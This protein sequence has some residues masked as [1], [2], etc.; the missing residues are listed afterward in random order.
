M[1]EHRQMKRGARIAIATVA[2]VSP[3][4]LIALAVV[5]PEIAVAILAVIWFAIIAV[6]CGVAARA[7]YN[8]LEDD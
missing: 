4:A 3:I 6:V 5:A 2:G 1:T 8:A 7:T